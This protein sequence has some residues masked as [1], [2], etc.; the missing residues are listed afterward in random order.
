MPIQTSFEKAHSSIINIDPIFSHALV[1]N[2][3]QGWS[4]SPEAWQKMTRGW[5]LV[6]TRAY[7]NAHHVYLGSY[8]SSYFP[9]II[10]PPFACAQTHTHTH[11]SGEE[12]VLFL[13]LPEAPSLCVCGVLHTRAQANI[14]TH[15]IQP[16]KV[17]VYSR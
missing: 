7:T 8:S 1:S 11:S 12:G 16:F 13:D 9:F 17:P 5:L 2:R 3:L 10:L 4:V 15:V 6:G 14:Y